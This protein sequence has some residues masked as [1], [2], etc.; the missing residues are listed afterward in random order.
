VAFRSRLE[1]SFAQA[2]KIAVVLSLLRKFDL[3]SLQW[4]VDETP[5]AH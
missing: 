5:P 2:F 4:M 1:G 3:A